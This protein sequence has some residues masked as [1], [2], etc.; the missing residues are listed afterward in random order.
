MTS[1]GGGATSSSDGGSST[2]SGTVPWIGRSGRGT[3]GISLAE[4][5][6]IFA[7]YVSLS[8][9]ERSVRDE[10][11]ATLDRSAKGVWDT[12]NTVPYGSYVLGLSLGGSDLDVAIDCVGPML[13]ENFDTFACY[14]SSEGF[15]VMGM[16]CNCTDGFMRLRGPSDLIVNIA[17]NASKSPVR[18][19]VNVLRGLLAEYPQVGPCVMTLRTVLAQCQL[20]DVSN[21]G[22]S[23]Y[24]IMLLTLR[25]AQLYGPGRCP[26]AGVLL[27]EF[28]RHYS[29][30]FD[31]ANIS[32]QVQAPGAPPVPPYKMHPDAPVSVVDPLDPS[33]NIAQG[34]TKLGQL[35]AML[36]YC[37]LALARWDVPEDQDE[38]FRGHTPLGTI[39]AAKAVASRRGR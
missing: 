18:E 12:S 21:G 16:V 36:K 13:Q 3:R 5:M 38:T 19:G 30:D 23:S 9:T 39:I 17:L 34:C 4:E 22:L 35:K 14:V 11:I 8:Q 32:I 37:E 28:L 29:A 20:M 25:L 2:R 7:G 24:A 1:G 27:R 10:V 15:D 33:N 31:Y 6:S 26:D